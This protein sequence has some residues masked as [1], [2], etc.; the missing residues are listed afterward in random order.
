ME[1]FN[2]KA[3][4]H[5]S[6]EQAV[7]MT[8]DFRAKHPDFIHGYYFGAEHYKKLLAIPGCTG[9]RTYHG[10]DEHG[11]HVHILAATDANGQTIFTA[12]DGTSTLVEQGQPCPPHC[13]TL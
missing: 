13:D 3:G 9:I 12:E 7:K 4:G 11:K 2:H 10:L 5:I 6:R 1:T 8:Q